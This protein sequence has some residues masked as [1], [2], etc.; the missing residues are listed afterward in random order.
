[1]VNEYFIVGESCVIFTLNYTERR[2]K[3]LRYNYMF[4]ID[5]IVL[6]WNFQDKAIIAHDR[7]G[8]CNVLVVSYIMP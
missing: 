3:C 5:M 8:K 4:L 1:M 6:D 2:E 7:N